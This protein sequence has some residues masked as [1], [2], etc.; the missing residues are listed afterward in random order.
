MQGTLNN[1]THKIAAPP[2]LSREI[3]FGTVPQKVISGTSGERTPS[4]NKSVCS[5]LSNYKKK[6]DSNK[7]EKQPEP[8][9]SAPSLRLFDPA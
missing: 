2:R 6:R 3:S 4:L 1:V 5:L 8:S 7:Q 9:V